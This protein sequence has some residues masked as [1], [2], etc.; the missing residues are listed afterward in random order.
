MVSGTADFIIPALSVGEN[1]GILYGGTTE[2]VF[3]TAKV[4][5]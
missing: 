4:F 2:K 5:P 1:V 3:E